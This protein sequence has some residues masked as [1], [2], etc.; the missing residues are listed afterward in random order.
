LF[1]YLLY[2]SLLGQQALGILFV[3]IS[4]V[5]LLY[6]LAVIVQNW[7]NT[8]KI[9]RCDECHFIALKQENGSIAVVYP[10]RRPK[11]RN[12]DS[13]KELRLLKQQIE[14]Y[15]GQWK[16]VPN[17]SKFVNLIDSKANSCRYYLDQDEYMTFSAAKVEKEFEIETSIRK[18][19]SRS[20]VTITLVSVA[21]SAVVTLILSIYHKQIFSFIV[22]PW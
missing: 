1:L 7:P 11:L 12:D 10:D 13:F 21:L 3:G 17:Y 6:Y 18:A 16:A 14:C 5:S 4:S 20:H 8:N 22:K 2:V 15:C 19:L 9:K